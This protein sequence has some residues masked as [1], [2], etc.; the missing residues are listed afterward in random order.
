MDLV[1]KRF[2]VRHRS[3]DGV[4]DVIGRVV[5]ADATGL[6]LERRDGALTFVAAGTVLAMREVP[7]RPVRTRPARAISADDLARVTSRG[8]PATESVPLGEWELRVA[9]GFTRRANSVAVHGDPGTPDP[10]GAVV[11]FYRDH[12]LRPLAQL[13]VG[14]HWDRRFEEVGWAPVGDQTSGAV[15]QVVDLR[16]AP[17]PDPDTEVHD[18]ASDAWLDRYAR[19]DDPAFARR[20]LEGPP[21]VGFVSIDDVAIGRVVLTGEW[22]GLAALEVDPEHRRRGLARRIIDTSLAWAVAH[23]A[24]KAYVQ[25]MRDN[26]AALELFAHYGFTTHHAYRYLTPD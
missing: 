25:T 1:G 3:D 7:D 5:Q 19:G 16:Q 23:G 9:G 15:V 8:W 11:E 26:A 21:T 18:H 4:R 10:F 12:G 24:D 22:A 2:S 14:S 20:V 6:R 17:A 13:I